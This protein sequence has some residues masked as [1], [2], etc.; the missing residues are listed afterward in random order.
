MVAALEPI[1]GTTH[2]L[3]IYQEQV[4]EIAQKLAGYTLGGADLLRR[5]MG[6]KK[7]EVLDAEYVPFSEGMKAQ[8]FNEHSIAALWGV[9]V[10]FSDYAFNKAHTA[11]YG[12]VSYW[13][14]YLK[15]NYPAEYMAALL[16][17]VGDDKDKSALYLG[18]CRRMG[19]RV[20][21]PDVNES[22]AQF[23][24]VGEDIRFGMQ[25]VRNVGAGV[26]EEIVRARTDSGR[27]TSFRDF[28]ARCPAV[29]CNKRTVESLIKAGAFDGLG[30]S[31]AGLLRVHE[32]Y[33]DAFVGVKRQEAIGQDSLFGS[34]GGAEVDAGEADLMGLTPVPAVEWDKSTLLSFEREMLG[35][36]VSDHP[37]FGVE[38]VLTA[39]ADTPI[40]T[41]T[42]DEGRP[43]G[44]TVTI[45]GL[46]TGL[47]VKRTKKGD[48][49]A[50]AT[51]EDL[52]GAVE[53]LFFPSTYLTVAGMLAQ[54]V[55]AVVRGRVNRRDDTV[56]IYASE[57]T[58]P[59]VSGAPRGPV[60]VQMETLRATPS[61]IKEL[62]SV[63]LSHP[64]TT[65][66]RLKLTK[67]GRS[68]DVLTLPQYRVEAS[69]ALFGDLKVLLGP[70][71]LVG[72]HG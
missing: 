34:L 64:G 37:L 31:R 43:E 25:A 1:L 4:M 35:L 10:P 69:E 46:V 48:L 24:A 67:P 2:G 28:L 72:G 13:T 44:S 47:Q 63:L 57:L 56:S 49:W 29:V 45:A 20:L 3:V 6:K 8:G 41:L 32:E 16:T 23:A 15:A 42:G 58:L 17:S 12:L 51:V 71:C 50:I 9:L 36:Y 22:V 19:I 59:D 26:V 53:C 61:R 21:P 33:V 27:F 14:A 68:V 62:Q 5:A 65:E 70:R 18:E 38:H 66:V 7:K 60:V 30:H 54:D 39:H 40:A 55:V 11:A 52:E